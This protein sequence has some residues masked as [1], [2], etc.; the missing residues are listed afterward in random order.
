MRSPSGL[1]SAVAANRRGSVIA[2]TGCLGLSSRITLRVTPSMSASGP[3][4][5][6]C[7]F[8][9]TTWLPSGE[10]LAPAVKSRL[11]GPSRTRTRP[12]TTST[13]SSVEVPVPL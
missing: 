8:S 12:V 3:R 9:K 10:Y 6:L 7:T 4:P 11:Q 1:Q 5:A 2:R 13:V